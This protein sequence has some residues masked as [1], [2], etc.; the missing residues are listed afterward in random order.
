[1]RYII[2]DTHF[3]HGKIIEYGQRPFDNVE[4]M[5]NRLVQCWN[6]IVD[7]KDTV[8]HLGDVRHHPDPHDEQYWF[9]KL[10][11]DI[12]LITGNHDNPPEGFDYH[13][14]KSAVIQH[15][16]YEFYLEHQPVGFSGWQIHGHAHNNDLMNYGFINHGTQR[17]N[18]SA[19]L[20]HYCPLSL[21]RLVRLLGESEDHDYLPEH[22]LPDI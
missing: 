18:I 17:V 13:V 1:M 15:G 8:F 6:T 21:T 11:G 10:N 19:E 16:K 9:D 4:Q 22:E 7:E 2:S 12:V 20:L 5:N 14:L 3:G